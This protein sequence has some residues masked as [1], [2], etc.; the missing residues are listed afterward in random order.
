MK[1]VNRIK[2][3]KDFALTI[4]NGKAYRND[5][6]VLHIAQNNLPYTRVGVSVSTK[7]GCAVVRNRVKRQIR[8]IADSLID[9]N[10]QSFDI[11][12]IARKSFL[13]VDFHDNKS[14]LSEL[15]LI[16]RIN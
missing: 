5:S 6:Y 2:E 3:S 13:D 7:M 4:K 11:V 12:I 1:I 14:L 15:L 10:K 16:G 8:A 9:Y